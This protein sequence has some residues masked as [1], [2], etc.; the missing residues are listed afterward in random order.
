LGRGLACGDLDNDGRLDLLIIAERT[1]L[2][3]FHNE[4]PSGHFVMLQ[5]EGAAPRSNRD[6]IGARVTLTAGGRRQ[7]AERIGG[8]SY[9]SANDHR[10]HF[11]LGAAT[12]VESVEVRWPSGQVDRYSGLAADTGYL[13]HEG[14]SEAATLPG[15]ER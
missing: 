1:P 12:R 4:G 6:A 2:A 9:L 7:M 5:L 3:Y 14:L 13:L 10:L 15:W 11:G 8:S